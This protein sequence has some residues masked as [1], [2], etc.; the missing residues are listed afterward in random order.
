MNTKEDLT[1]VELAMSRTLSKLLSNNAVRIVGFGIVQDLSKL[2][3]SFPHLPCF[4]TFHS[5][6]DLHSLSR[7]TFPKKPKHFM[8]SLQKTTSIL[9]RKRLDKAEQCS[10]WNVR[11][12]RPTQLEYASLDATILPILLGKILHS[13]CVVD[14][15]NGFFLRK[16]AGIQTS[17]RFTFLED[18]DDRAYNI[19]MG[20]LKT[21]YMDLKLA[22][23][24]WPTLKKEAPALPEKLSHGQNA[25]LFSTRKEPKVKKPREWKVKKNAIELTLLSGDLG[26]LPEAGMEL[27]YTKESCIEHIVKKEVIDA[28]PDNSY[29]RYNRRG[30]IVELANCWMLFVNFG[31]GKIHSKYEN[32][33]LE[34]AKK[35][36]FTINPSRHDDGE[37]LQN[38]LIQEDSGMYRKGVLLFIR[39]SSS[40]KFISCGECTCDNH[41]VNEDNDLVNIVLELKQFEDLKEDVNGEMS[42]YM[43]LVSENLSSE[44][45]DV[46]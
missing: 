29:L 13:D 40:G 33:F 39:G 19:P 28:L 2:A 45:E 38:L 18:H 41:R 17:Y 26:H 4:R 15:E 16:N 1:E 36:T 9:L 37:L 20:S 21:S 31:V 34:G 7:L 22:R 46:S 30:G 3:A 6:V 35:V 11:P 5:V 25:V 10:E 8:S 24:M 42:T 27:G 12:L 32:V 23:Q 43:R 44:V 14:Q